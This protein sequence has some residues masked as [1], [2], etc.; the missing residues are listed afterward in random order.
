M[1][2]FVMKR[3]TDGTLRPVGCTRQDFATEGAALAA[4]EI[5]WAGA[6]AAEVPKVEHC[7]RC[8]AWHIASDWKGYIPTTNAVMRS[9]TARLNRAAR[10]NPHR[11]GAA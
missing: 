1:A 6:P 10:R 7:R 5:R 2:T 9:H 3:T 4:R 8:D 11:R